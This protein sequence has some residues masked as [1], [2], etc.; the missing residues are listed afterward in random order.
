[1]GDNQGPK[2]VDIEKRINSIK[3]LMKEFGVQE[4]SFNEKLTTNGGN[5]IVAGLVIAVCAAIINDWDNFKR[6]LTGHP[7]K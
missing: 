7:E 3:I 1:L 5:P 6:G 2:K 4:L